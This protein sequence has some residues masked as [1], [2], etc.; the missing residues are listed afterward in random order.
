MTNKEQATA[1]ATGTTAAAT[2]A[3][4]NSRFLRFAAE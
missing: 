1:I 4:S 2:K 3:N